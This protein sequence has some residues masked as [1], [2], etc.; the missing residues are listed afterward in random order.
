MDQSVN[1]KNIGVCMAQ[2]QATIEN[3]LQQYEG[4]FTITRPHCFAGNEIPA[5]AYFTQK[6]EKYI[7]VRRAQL[8]AIET[9]EHVF[10]MDAKELTPAV[11]EREKQRLLQAEKDYVRPNRDHMCSFITLVLLCGSIDTGVQ[12]EIQRLRYTKYYKAGIWGYSTVRVAAIDLTR[13]KFVL[14]RQA[15]VIRKVMERALRG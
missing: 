12:K 10:I 5:Y 9:N 4:Y 3:L 7:L 13:E 11:W 14:N 1:R 8:Y 2:L 6:I 15:K